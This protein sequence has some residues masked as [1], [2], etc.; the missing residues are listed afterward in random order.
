MNSITLSICM[1]TFKR[2]AFI[3]E[4]L[5]SIIS[6]ATDEVEIVVVDGAS[7]D[8]TEQVVRQYEL[9]FPRLRYFRQETNMGVDRDFNRAVQLASGK[10]CWLMPDD[11]VLKPRAI[12][13]VLDEIRHNYGLIIVNKEIRNADLSK[14]IDSKRLPIS[15]NRV[16]KPNDS[17]CLMAEVGYYLAYIGCVVIKRE[18]WETRDKEKY[19]GTDHIHVGIIFQR[20][21]IEQVLVIAEPLISFRY[22]NALWM[23]KSFETWM[24]KW[25]N[26]IWSFPDYSDWAKR[27]VC[28]RE[29]WRKM[30]T[31]MNYRALG[32]YSSKEYYLWLEPRLGSM[33]ERFA[34]KAVAQFPP[35]VVNLVGI[36]Y[37]LFFRS[38]SNLPVW[39][40]KNSRFYY[41]N[42]LKSFHRRMAIIFKPSTVG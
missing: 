25:P 13:V 2:A 37:L 42:C 11:D 7:P 17:Q 3:G 10:Y 4:T 33:F 41:L 36:I 15:V 21:F 6:Q 39:D 18:M 16:Y 20:P 24:F 14:V 9:R 26:L 1:A 8:E 32:V 12:S 28:P 5:E 31:L 27:S 35:C 22:G 40:L 30:T 38:R 23:E 34:T 19:F 29:P